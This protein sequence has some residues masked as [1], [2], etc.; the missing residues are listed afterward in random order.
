MQLSQLVTSLETSQKL[1]ALGVE[2]KSLFYHVRE[3]D[4]DEWELV[5]GDWYNWHEYPIYKDYQQRLPA[6]TSAELWEMMKKENISSGYIEEDMW[7]WA[8]CLER[9]KQRY[10]GSPITTN[11]EHKPIT[12]DD[13]LS[14]F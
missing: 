2:Q 1:K 6:F 3:S 7:W 14:R 5:F 13:I 12:G 11:V 9:Y 8:E 4:N 10:E